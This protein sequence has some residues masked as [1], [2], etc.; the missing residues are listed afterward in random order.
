M[1]NR[2]HH[3]IHQKINHYLNLHLFSNNAAWYAKDIPD[4]RSDDEVTEDME[5]ILKVAPELIE[6]T[7]VWFD[8]REC[9][10]LGRLI[11]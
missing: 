11:I 9:L 1:V 7:T 4:K 8:D 6:D 10:A 2:T 3:P 5:W